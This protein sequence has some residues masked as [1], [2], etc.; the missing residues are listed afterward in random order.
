[1]KQV[2]IKE[3]FKSI[4]G[5]G[6]FIGYQQ[7][8][9]RFGGCNLK[10]TYCDTAHD[11]ISEKFQVYYHWTH[12]ECK[13]V[14]NPISSA[15]LVDLV[16]GMDL[17]DIHSISLTGGEPLIQDE[18]LQEFLPAI[19]SI[20]DSKIFLET[21]GTLA[22]ELDRIAEWVDYV[23]MDFKLSS[24]VE[25][26]KNILAKHEEFIKICSLHG[27][28]TYVKV[29]LDD[30]F[31]QKELMMYLDLLTETMENVCLYIQPMMKGDQFL[32]SKDKMNRVFQACQEK[33]LEVR[34]I[35]QVHKFLRVI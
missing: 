27:L 5:E 16:A 6:E 10:C 14:E 28:H 23:S 31:N 8:F 1:M 18:F 13:I 30:Y 19:I 26:E 11:S 21:N 7:L 29:V 25:N 4:Q 32:L 34:I 17:E 9:I 24:Y 2:N 35:P 15:D 33:K 20:T 12:D 22:Q 3:I